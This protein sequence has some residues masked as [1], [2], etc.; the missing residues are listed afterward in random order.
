MLGLE[1]IQEV[2]VRGTP[3]CLKGVP[4]TLTCFPPERDLEKKIQYKSRSD[5]P[6]S[7]DQEK[8][9]DVR[10][11]LACVYCSFIFFPLRLL[12][13]EINTQWFS[14]CFYHCEKPLFTVVL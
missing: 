2:S 11:S 13:C 14:Q 10:Q 6:L 9:K 4:L 3:S 12:Q 5:F 7:L 8:P 1:T